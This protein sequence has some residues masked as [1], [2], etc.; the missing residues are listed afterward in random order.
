MR[1][2]DI[3][4]QYVNTGKQI[5]KYQFDKLNSSLL[6]SY[7][8]TRIRATRPF[9]L[10]EFDKA[11]DAIKN[12]YIDYALRSHIDE[13]SDTYYGNLTE[14]NKLSSF[15]YE[16]TISI[17]LPIFMKNNLFNKLMNIRTVSCLLIFNFDIENIGK[18]LGEKFID[19]RKNFFESRRQELIFA[20]KCDNI[21]GIFKLFDINID[22]YTDDIL[23]VVFA[24]TDDVLKISK[25]FK[26]R[27]ANFF[28]NLSPDDFENIFRQ[29][30]DRTNLKDAYRLYKKK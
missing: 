12:E 28:Q 19:F 18:I 26:E 9:S 10:Y 21:L 2:R 11:N 16:H 27:A 22:E 20:T 15:L 4:K 24:H 14:I 25:L 3:I 17:Y 13:S 29:S 5:P 23:Q 8:R 1:N 6:K 30:N 7:Y